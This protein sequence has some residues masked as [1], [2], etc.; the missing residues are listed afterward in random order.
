M[1]RLLG[2]IGSTAAMLPAIAFAQ[3][4]PPGDF[5]VSAPELGLLIMAGAVAV[6][7]VRRAWQ[8]DR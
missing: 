1:R 3:K 7:I 5:G 6:P 4:A 2:I 8:K